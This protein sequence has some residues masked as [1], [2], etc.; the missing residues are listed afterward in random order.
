MRRGDMRQ[1]Y[2]ICTV[3][4]PGVH[5]KVRIR[6]LWHHRRD[7]QP[8]MHQLQSHCVK[9]WALCEGMDAPATD[10]HRRSLSRQRTSRNPGFPVRRCP[11]APTGA[12]PRHRSLAARDRRLRDHVG[13]SLASGFLCPGCRHVT[14]VPQRSLP[15]AAL[16]PGLSQWRPVGALGVQGSSRFALSRPTSK[17][18]RRS[19]NGGL[20]IAEG[21]IVVRAL[22]C[23]RKSAL[24]ATQSRQSPQGGL[25]VRQSTRQGSRDPDT[26]LRVAAAGV[27]KRI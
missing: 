24:C 7:H 2:F 3:R 13:W 26:D 27:H 6:I 11:N 9:E 15:L 16:H 17:L 21:K 1:W 12:V 8:L 23:R 25:G 10:D 4:I 14:R 19:P 22:S 20:L 5:H 18:N